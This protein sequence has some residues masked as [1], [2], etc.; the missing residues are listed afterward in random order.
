MKKYIV[1]T[2]YTCN[3]KTV[4][5]LDK[6]SEKE[7]S[8][9][10]NREDG[11]VEVIEVKL[12]NRKTK[13]IGDKSSHSSTATPQKDF[14]EK[15]IINN[16][17]GISNFLSCPKSTVYLSFCLL[18]EN[19]KNVVIGVDSIENL[20]QNMK[21]TSYVDKIREC[22]DILLTLECTSEKEILPTMWK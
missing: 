21:F 2:Y 3:F 5:R 7:L 6:L 8:K 9:I 15:D 20:N 1:E 14:V 16:I 4:H 18:N 10:E 12:N 17:N 22:Y 13:T 11:E 19:I